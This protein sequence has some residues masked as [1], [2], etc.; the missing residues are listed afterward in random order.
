MQFKRK[1]R[2]CVVCLVENGLNIAFFATLKLDRR[3]TFM[4]FSYNLK[5]AQKG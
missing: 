2:T 5:K 1:R 3:T 4:L